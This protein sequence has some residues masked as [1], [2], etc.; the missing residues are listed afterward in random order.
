MKLK[1]SHENNTTTKA[2]NRK[3]SYYLIC[4]LC[5]SDT[6]CNCTRDL[7]KPLPQSGA[8]ILVAILLAILLALFYIHSSCSSAV[9][10]HSACVS[11]SIFEEKV[12]IEKGRG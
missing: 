10:R 9:R 7:V 12:E 8:D 3:L 4:Y 11:C 1:Q 6:T 2:K 5:V